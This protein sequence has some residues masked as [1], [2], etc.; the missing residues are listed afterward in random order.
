M[1]IVAR[2]IYDFFFSNEDEFEDELKAL[3][4]EDSGAEVNVAAYTDKQKFR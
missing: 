1:C 4:L 2:F 3:G